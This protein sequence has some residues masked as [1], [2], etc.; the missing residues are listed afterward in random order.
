MVLSISQIV[1]LVLLS[2]FGVKTS[3]LLIV[4]GFIQTSVSSDGP[5]LTSANKNV[6]F[7]SVRVLLAGRGLIFFLL[8]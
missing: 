2:G 5:S 3:Q 1:A 4:W 8:F 6:T 7:Q